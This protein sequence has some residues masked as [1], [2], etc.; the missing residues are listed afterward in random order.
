MA[1]HIKIK[2]GYDNLVHVDAVSNDYTL[3][4]LETAGDPGLDINKG[5]RTKEKVDCRDCISI[6]NLCKTV[7]TTDI[8][9]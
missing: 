3:C 4:G 5:I 2:T 9:P 6:V 1:L 8:K 7:K